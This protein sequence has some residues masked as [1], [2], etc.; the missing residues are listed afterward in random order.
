MNDTIDQFMW[1]FQSHFRGRVESG[2][3]Q[4]L[5]KIG[6]PVEVRVVLVGFAL[7]SS[8]RH[9]ICV[10]PES[11]TLQA[12]HLAGVLARTD[13]MF[14]ANPD[15]KMFFSD[16]RLHKLRR[17]G[18]F[19]R[20]RADALV[21][22]IEASGVFDGLTFFVSDAAP[23]DSYEVHTCVGVPTTALDSFPALDNSV[24]ERVYVG[25]SLQHEAITECLRRADNDLYLPNPGTRLFPLGM[26]EDIIKAAA[27][28]LTDGTAYRATG[29]STDLFSWVNAFASLGYERAGA[30]GYL[31]IAPR[32]KVIDQLLVRFQHQVPLR[33]ARSMRKLLELSD[34]STSVLVDH[35]GAYGLGSC[36]SGT[37][38]V[39][40]SVT[41]H[42]QWEMRVNG[43][44][45]M[46][47]AYG[48]A[49]LP[50]PLLDVDKFRDTA[51]RILGP[52]E[53]SR[54]WAIIQKAQT[55]GH[56]TS[57]VVSSDPEGEAAR[58]GAEAVSIDPALL[59]PTEIVRLS[60]VDGA[61]LL[62]SDGRCHAFGVIL[63][64]KAS[65]QG[66][67][68][69]GSRF[70]SAVRYQSTPGAGS[71]VVVISDD[72]TVDLIPPLRPRMHREHVEAAVRAFRACCEAEY[73]DGGEFYRTYERVKGF[74]FYL[75]G[76][77]CRVVNEC[78]ENE[79]LCRFE[80]GNLVISQAPFQPHP[81]MDE[82]YFL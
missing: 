7:D 49:T 12:D 17:D 28:R 24:V 1:G 56:G 54:I 55:S 3:S 53:L 50:R 68:A 65:G 26:T 80:A 27:E 59:E 46:R 11:G 75:D 9:Q 10:E 62:G 6:L 48:Q 71:I 16:P 42:A 63:D 35:Q 36:V 52:I 76:E 29:Q 79:M 67:P 34:D 25:R 69:R 64:G 41:G 8:Q 32:E 44:A 47:V 21:E 72:G 57:L 82:S 66:D 31:V 74:V 70:N 2:I 45:L 58:L 23:I 78:Y 39:E 73:V 37:D 38:V 51:E 40:I 61:I 14:D 18:L 4:V 22:A 43:S 77:Q 5:S 60:R 30:G 20:S 13:E 19:R 15:S 81:D 33:Q